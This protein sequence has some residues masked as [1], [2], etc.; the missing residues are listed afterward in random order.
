[1]TDRNENRPIIDIRFLA[2]QLDLDPEET[3]ILCR[4]LFRKIADAQGAFGQEVRAVAE[5]TSIDAS[6]ARVLAE[7]LARDMRKPIPPARETLAMR[8]NEIADNAREKVSD[9]TDRVSQ[10]VASIDVG[11]LREDGALKVAQLRER[12]AEVD[13]SEATD[14]AKEFGHKAASGVKGL[15]GRV[16]NRFKTGEPVQPALDRED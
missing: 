12:A 1:M 13:L 10:G 9:L 14:Q 2:E 8:A 7:L 3:Q 11:S 15:V 6:T 16:R 5:G 4:R